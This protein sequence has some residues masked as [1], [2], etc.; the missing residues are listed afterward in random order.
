MFNHLDIWEASCVLL[1]LEVVLFMRVTCYCI[2]LK[3]AVKYLLVG[4]LTH[5]KCINSSKLVVTYFPAALHLSMIV[6]RKGHDLSPLSGD[7]PSHHPNTYTNW[8]DCPHCHAHLQS[9]E[10]DVDHRTPHTQRATVTRWPLRPPPQV[11]HI[12]QMSWCIPQ[13]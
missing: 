10:E 2:L 12:P 3:D 1:F 9:E 5:D 8:P 6:L 13:R 7:S 11:S 4:M